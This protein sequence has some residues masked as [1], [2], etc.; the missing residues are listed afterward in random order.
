MI[1]D[2]ESTPSEDAMKP[3]EMTTKYLGH[4]V[5]LIDVAGEVFERINSNFERSSTLGKML[6]RHW[7]VQRNCL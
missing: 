4:Y 2:I 6:S 3:A 1:F 7:V 5:N